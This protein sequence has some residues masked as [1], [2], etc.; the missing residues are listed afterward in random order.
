MGSRNEP[1]SGGA[2]LSGCR[3]AEIEALQVGIDPV[4]PA[5]GWLK[6]PF[7]K[8][9]SSLDELR[10]VNHRIH[11]KLFIADNVLALI[12]GRN[13]GD[14]YYMRAE[15]GEN[16]AGIFTRISQASS[17]MI[18]RGGFCAP[19]KTMNRSRSVWFIV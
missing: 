9:L 11:N 7:A 6:L 18:V 5:R 8:L 1:T 2:G 15:E 19:E 10:R 12:G 3:H 17:W 13:I 16:C 4:W 14:T